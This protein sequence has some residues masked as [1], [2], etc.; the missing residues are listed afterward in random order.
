MDLGRLT[1][2]MKQS[3]V[4]KRSEAVIKARTGTG[5]FFEL[6]MDPICNL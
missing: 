3:D 5:F 1:N 2:Q 6:L 4:S